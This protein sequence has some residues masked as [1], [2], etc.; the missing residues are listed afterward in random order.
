MR[1]SPTKSLATGSPIPDLSLSK[2][3]PIQLDTPPQII[4]PQDLQ[5]LATL[6]DKP[7]ILCDTFTNHLTLSNNPKTDLRAKIERDFLLFAFFWAN[8]QSFEIENI[9]IFLGFIHGLYHSI[10]Q[11]GADKNKLISEIEEKM[12][13]GG[14]EGYT[15]G[16]STFSEESLKIILQFVRIS[17]VQHFELYNYVLTKERPIQSVKQEVS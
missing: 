2:P 9:S 15:G 12:R 10:A 16:M 8:K 5:H 13:G 7:E 4:S 14:L 3:E 11:E 1:K 17:L 6:V